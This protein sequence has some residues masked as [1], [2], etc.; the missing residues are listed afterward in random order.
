MTGAGAQT[1]VAAVPKP[2]TVT[3][4]HVNLIAFERMVY[5]RDMIQAGLE[6][7]RIVG[8]LRMGSLFA[9]EDL[10]RQQ[11]EPVRSVLY[12]RLVSA[13][14]ALIADPGFSFTEKGFQQLTLFSPTVNAIFAAS[15]YATSDHLIRLIAVNP[16]EPDPEKLDF[17]DTADLAKV[18]ATWCLGSRVSVNFEKAFDGA[19]DFLLP[20]WLGMI[21]TACALDSRSHERREELIGMGR[22]FAQATLPESALQA[23]SD[24]Y[25][26]CSYAVRPDKH[27][28]KRVLGRIAYRAFASRIGAG[29]AQALKARTAARRPIDQRPVIFMP[30]EWWTSFH[31]MYRVYQPVVEQ[32]RERF[33]VVASVKASQTDEKATACF[34]EVIDLPNDIALDQIV[35]SIRKLAPDVIYYLSSGMA[36]WWVAIAQVRLAPIQML[37]LGHPATTMSP[38][39]DYALVEEGLAPEAD[40]FS[41][42][43]LELPPG[44]LRFVKRADTETSLF[45]R[46][47]KV[48]AER[49]MAERVCRIAI[50]AMVAKLTVPFLELLGRVAARALQEY[51][52]DVVYHFFP[53]QIATGLAAVDRLL[54]ARFPNCIVRPRADYEQ[55]L[56]WLAQC[57]LHASPFPF[58]GTNSNVDSLALG[59]PIIALE[60][61]REPHE[62]YDAAM[63]RRAGLGEF[64]AG[65]VEEYEEIL[66]DNITNAA[67]KIDPGC[68]NVFFEPLEGP[69]AGAFVRAIEYV[70]RN[71]H[72]I[73]QRKRD[74][75]VRWQEY[76]LGDKHE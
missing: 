70:Y 28:V 5:Q 24:A 57:D 35:Q 16:F 65:S 37:S 34:D 40:A 13:A 20:W 69:A 45:E 76:T 1:E 30:L 23:L 10:Q 25:M 64:V 7:I 26:H 32:L 29:S 52:V 74:K 68:V 12:T 21:S 11:A 51:D 63:L 60:G 56:A 18:M 50:P 15:H 6:L 4:E 53:N 8:M 48:H 3:I 67:P 41:E 27:E 17:A 42:R 38:A 31:A 22:F 55:Y 72:Q 39:M 2:G 54:R 75:R 71:H 49:I 59:I 62:R 9:H 36:L 19:P 47:R 66:L 61:P 58:G 14:T 73:K 43:I 46:M 44:A 33:R